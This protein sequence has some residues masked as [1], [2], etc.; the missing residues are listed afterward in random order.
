VAN[1][2][3]VTTWFLCSALDSLLCAMEGVTGVLY[4]F[5]LLCQNAVALY[6]V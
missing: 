4:I 6:D 2:R 1:V 5:Q 3:L